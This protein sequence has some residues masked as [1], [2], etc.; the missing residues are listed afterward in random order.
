MLLC[1]Y[2][3]SWNVDWHKGICKEC[4]EPVSDEEYK[5]CV[6]EIVRKEFN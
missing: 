2:C 1:P 6:I 3:F 4:R 5:K